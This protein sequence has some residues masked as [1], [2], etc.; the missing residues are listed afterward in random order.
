MLE[1]RVLT[2]FLCNIDQ[3]PKDLL[4]LFLRETFEQRKD[5]LGRFLPQEIR[6]RVGQ[7]LMRFD[8]A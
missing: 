6:T 4:L 2:S 1:E 7:T 5:F 3:I 8:I